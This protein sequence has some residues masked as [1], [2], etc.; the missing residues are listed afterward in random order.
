[1]TEISIIGVDL[2]KDVFQLHCARTNVA[3]A[4]GKKTPRAQFQSCTCHRACGI[5][6]SGESRITVRTR[7][8]QQSR[9]VASGKSCSPD[10]GAQREIALPAYQR[11]R[12]S[13]L[14]VDSVSS[15]L[16]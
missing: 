14:L 1:M 8:V 2:A 6:P 9:L 11:S 3:V 13:G 5:I 4:F 12:D 10:A 7:F 15:D 16:R